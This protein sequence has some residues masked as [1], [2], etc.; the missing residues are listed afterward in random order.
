MKILI[1]P[2][3]F[4]GSLSHRQAGRAIE[5][6]LRRA[7]LDATFVQLPLADGGDG[8]LEALLV[9]GGQRVEVDT[10]DALSRPIKAAYGVLPDGETAVIELA[11]ASGLGQLRPTERDVLRATTYG[12]GLVL[13]AAFE[14]G[15]RRFIIGLGGSATHD[16]AMGALSGLGVVF[17]DAR[18][19]KLI[20]GGGVLRRVAKIDLSGLSTGWGEADIVIASDVTNAA[21][22]EQGAAAV[23]APQKGASSADVQHLEAGTQHFLTLLAGQTGRD[24]LALPGGGA[25]GAFAAGL[26][27]VLGG[28]MESGVDLVL[29]HL[30]VDEHLQ[31][32]S[33]VI[34]GE[35]RLD[36]QTLG[37]KAPLG[38]ARLAAAYGVPTIA[39]VGSVGADVDDARLRAVGIEAV[40]PII[41]RPMSVE[42]AMANAAVLLERAAARA[43]ALLQMRL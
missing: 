3:A 10:Y 33:L 43:G 34:T 41:E 30:Q 4:K 40:L 37:G 13:R 8:T 23:F 15:R 1:A 25:A 35:G 29:R 12:T 24:V 6:G 7:G 9:Q 28:R 31:G 21:V 16:A 19:R 22:G 5:A 17:C 32:T 38:I 26:L 20:P 36:G 11:L 14:A 2:T 18:G 39:I 27:C 42:E